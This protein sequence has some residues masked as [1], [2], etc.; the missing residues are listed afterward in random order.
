MLGEHVNQQGSYAGPDRLRF[1]MSHP[2]ALRAEEVEQVEALVNGQ[3]FRNQALVSTV[4]DLEAAKARGVM[5]LFGEKYQ[6]RVRVVD[7]P[8]PISDGIRARSADS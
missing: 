2:K 7:V 6:D 5:A 8:E 3:V 1:D 4:E